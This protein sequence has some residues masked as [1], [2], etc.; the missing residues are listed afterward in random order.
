MDFREDK[1]LQL[2]GQAAEFK[3]ESKFE[4]LPVTLQSLHKAISQSLDN[5]R[6]WMQNQLEL[7]SSW[8]HAQAQL[9][10][11][12]HANTIYTNTQGVSESAA[13]TAGSNSPAW[14]KMIKAGVRL[15][16][17][18]HDCSGIASQVTPQGCHQHANAYGG[19]GRVRIGDRLHPF[20]CLLPLGYHSCYTDLVQ[21]SKKF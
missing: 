21:E 13:V 9:G 8:G 3:F 7:P 20:L 4:P 11:V 18:N 10:R 19:K 14:E 2:I 5:R 12:A 16:F 15:S 17:N 1:P 6:F